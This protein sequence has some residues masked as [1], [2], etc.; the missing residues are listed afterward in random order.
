MNKFLRFYDTTIGKKVV[1]ALTGLVLL[2][3]VVGHVA[4]NLKAFGGYGADG[5]HKLDHYAEFLRSFGADVLG[6]S[7]F[8]WMARVGLLVCLVL[9][10]LTIIQ[11][12]LRN[13]KAN[14][15][16]Y[17][18]ENYRAASLASRTMFWGGMLLFVFIIYHILHFTTGTLHGSFHHGAVYANI[19][20]AFQNP[21]VTGFY[22]VAMCALGLHLYH[23]GW[24][25]FQTLGLDN[26]DWNPMI[27]LAV[28]AGSVAIVLGFISV[29]IAIFT[30]ILGPPV[31]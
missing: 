1:V 24:S 13:A 10:V 11:L 18:G 12:R 16:R 8:L 28:Q 19:H 30:G 7:G 2:S 4:G 14:P 17:Q 26:P 6:H 29:P 5:E 31:G 23:G 9:H 3:F 25:L 22:V 20:Y 21:I 15:D 27:R